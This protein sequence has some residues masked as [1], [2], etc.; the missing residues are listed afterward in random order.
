MIKFEVSK[1]IEIDTERHY[2]GKRTSARHVKS[3]LQHHPISKKKGCY[4][5]AMRAGKGRRLVYIGMT[6]AQSFASEMSAPHKIKKINEGMRYTKRGTLTCLLLYKAGKGAGP[7][8]ANILNIESWLIQ[9]AY[10]NQ[11]YLTNTNKLPRPKW[12]ISG[13]VNNGAGNPGNGKILRKALG[14][15]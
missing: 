5:F 14:I 2:A 6:K 1:E 9:T 7:S 11:P 4:V 3:A 12:L 13:V 10:A 8:K 15:K